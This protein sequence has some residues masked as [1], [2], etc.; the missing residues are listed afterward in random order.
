[1]VHWMVTSHSCI[2][3]SET[4]GMNEAIAEMRGH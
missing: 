2:F 4:K 1:M 3:Q